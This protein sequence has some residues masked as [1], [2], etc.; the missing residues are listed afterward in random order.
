MMTWFLVAFEGLLFSCC[1]CV[2]CYIARALRGGG[3]GEEE[4]EEDDDDDDEGKHR[5]KLKTA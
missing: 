1:I 4:E 3:G 5:K 2:Q